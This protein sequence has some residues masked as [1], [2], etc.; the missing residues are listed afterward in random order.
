L[1]PIA[2]KG[3]TVLQAEDNLSSEEFSAKLK[4]MSQADFL[5]LRKIGSQYAAGTIGTWEDLLHEAI[6]LTLQGERHCKRSLTVLAHL[7]STMR[8]LA[9]N[10][11]K[12]DG[13]ISTVSIGSPIDSND[14]DGLTIDPQDSTPNSEI[15]L[16]HQECLN[17]L[18]GLFENEDE[19]TGLVLTGVAMG[20]NPAEIQA[21]VGITSTEYDTIRKRIR[22]SI[23]KAYPEGLPI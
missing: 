9:S 3:K 6:C 7:H 17:T 5:R 19:N 12:K 1:E 13:R 8:S 21:Q 2:V 18:F 10:V 4:A 16:S 14:E 23:N 11:R 22:R 20:Q 15:R